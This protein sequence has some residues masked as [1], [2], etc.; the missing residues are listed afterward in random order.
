MAG[1]IGHLH[2]ADIVREIRTKGKHDLEKIKVNA[3]GPLFER[4]EGTEMVA[5]KNPRRQRLGDKF[6]LCVF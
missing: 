3:M 1:D 5:W 2:L 4:E 6:C